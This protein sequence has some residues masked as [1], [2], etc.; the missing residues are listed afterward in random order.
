MKSTD[1]H[2][3]EALDKKNPPSFKTT[4]TPETGLCRAFRKTNPKA[5]AQGKHARNLTWVF[6][7]RSC[8]MSSTM[9]PSSL[10][11][12]K[13]N[14]AARLVNQQGAMLSD[15]T[16]KKKKKKRRQTCSDNCQSN[17]CPALE[18]CRKSHI[19]YRYLT[20][21]DL[22]GK[23][24]VGMTVRQPASCS[25]PW[26]S[27]SGKS[28]SGAHGFWWP[29]QIKTQRKEQTKLSFKIPSQNHADLRLHIEEAL[30]I[31]TRAETNPDFIESES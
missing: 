25:G 24:Y 11:L 28:T 4:T 9:A 17:L 26:T 15:L 2:K 27:T 13:H 16:K 22:C 10:I 6:V 20:T 18:I 7:S 14:I 19:V 30:A 12:K 31:K 8:R 1:K 21:C 3:K 29:L 23:R 5:D